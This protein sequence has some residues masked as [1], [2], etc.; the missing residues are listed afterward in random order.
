MDRLTVNEFEELYAL[1]AFFVQLAPELKSPIKGHS[2]KKKRNINA[3]ELHRLY[4]ENNRNVGVVPA[5]V[6]CV[7][8]DVD[9]GQ[10]DLAVDI[11]QEKTGVAP[12]VVLPSSNPNNRHVW[13]KLSGGAFNTLIWQWPLSTDEPDYE[14]EVRCKNAYVAVPNKQYATELIAALQIEYKD[15]DGLC[16]ADVTP[17]LDVEDFAATETQED[18]PNQLPKAMLERMASRALKFISP[19]VDMRTW[20]KIGMGLYRSFGDDGFGLF[21]KWSAK[22]EKYR[23]EEMPDRWRSFSDT[24]VSIGSLFHYAKEHGGFD[25]SENLE[26]IR[27]DFEKSARFSG[28]ELQ[29]VYDDVD[30]AVEEHRRESVKKR[31]IEVEKAEAEGNLDDQLRR[32]GFTTYND[33]LDYEPR[34]P[35]NDIVKGI[36]IPN[37]RHLLIGHSKVGKTML[38]EYIGM[39]I[40]TGRDFFDLQ[41]KQSRVLYI[42]ME[43][44]MAIYADR[45]KAIRR[46]MGLSEQEDADVQQRVL[47][48]FDRKFSLAEEAH[49]DNLILTVIAL[50]IDM[51]VF[52]SLSRVTGKY[53]EE[54][55]DDMKRFN[56]LMDTLRD[57]PRLP[58]GGF[59]WVMIHHMGQ[60]ADP[61]NI[62]AGRGVTEITAW[63]DQ[64]I[65]IYRQDGKLCLYIHPGNV[66]PPEDEIWYR[67]SSNTVPDLALG[68][69]VDIVTFEQ[70][71]P[72]QTLDEH[73]ES[74]QQEKADKDAE[75]QELIVALL[76]RAQDWVETT[77]IHTALGYDGF[78]ERRINTAI[79]ALAD[80]SVIER[81]RNPG[82]CRI[83]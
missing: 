14:G 30:D 76:T 32:Q 77:A 70:A 63:Y 7:V 42:D 38:S 1:G 35:A 13:F 11:L 44:S 73:N 59:T 4:E 31:E 23:A 47:W 83:S 20:Y 26:K 79:K 65:S 12:L 45:T 69:D 49:R 39:C 36:I 82:R 67:Q 19:D 54:N 21:D 41:V 37:Q 27:E 48:R 52:D 6:G 34:D 43:T 56:K 50:K 18:A 5:S 57:D 24:R 64:I 78:G 62:N 17:L 68:R 2:W 74:Q 80:D 61:R 9:K 22:S 29:Q 28:A 72:P 81:T 51:V 3:T 75:C 33:L 40:A 8:I 66:A 16:R 60:G 10:A 25:Y 46:G 55:N 58:D 53:K 15:A 71:E